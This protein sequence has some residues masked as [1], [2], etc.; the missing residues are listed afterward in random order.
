MHA[1]DTYAY[2]RPS[3]CYLWF[4]LACFCTYCD[5]LVV[6]LYGVPIPETHWFANWSFIILTFIPQGIPMTGTWFH[7]CAKQAGTQTNK[8]WNFEVFE[9][10]A[11]IYFFKLLRF[12]VFFAANL[13]LQ[14]LQVHLT[15]D[16]LPEGDHTFDVSCNK[17][18]TVW[19]HVAK[20]SESPV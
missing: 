18:E 6:F 4:D 19:Q 11:H 16:T 7:W 9:F 20:S 15:P 10:A 17:Q 14:L 13:L 1:I 12:N 8:E 5:A 3:C 2:A